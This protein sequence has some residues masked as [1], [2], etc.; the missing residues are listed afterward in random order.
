[1]SRVTFE[2][3]IDKKPSESFSGLPESSFKEYLESQK[4]VKETHGCIIKTTETKDSVNPPLNNGF[5]GAAFSAY[6]KHLNWIISPD[7]VWIAIMSAFAQYVDTHSEE[8]RSSFVKHDGQIELEA[9]G[10]GTIYTANYD[11]LIDQ[12]RNKIDKNTVDEVAPWIECGFSTTTQKERTVSKLI[13]MGA[14][15]NYFTYKM[16]LECGIPTVTLLGTLDDWTNIRSRIDLFAKYGLEEWRNVLAFV[17]DKF[18][19]S[20]KGTVNKDFW[21]GVVNKHYGFSGPDYITGWIL[22][23]IPFDSEGKYILGDFDDCIKNHN[24]YGYVNTDR[25]PMS[26]VDVPVL[27]NDNGKHYNTNF[28]AGAFMTTYDPDTFSVGTSLDWAISIIDK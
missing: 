26:A 27:I 24:D 2:V 28:Y 22:T 14:M 18:I 6:S 16:S 21:N 10:S 20:Y 13:L 4:C 7:D 8:M 3:S 17:L 11:D 23:F 15:K 25:I 9:Y 5:V 12:L 1:M 19:D